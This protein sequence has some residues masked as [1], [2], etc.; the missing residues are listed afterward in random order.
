MKETRLNNLKINNIYLIFQTFKY[1]KY[2]AIARVEEIWRNTVK[3]REVSNYI[4]LD[5]NT[6]KIKSDLD[7]LEW[8]LDINA[9]RNKEKISIFIISDEEIFRNVIMETI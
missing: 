8:S 9:V 1:E 7:F 2:L 6:H 4:V 3:L 5:R